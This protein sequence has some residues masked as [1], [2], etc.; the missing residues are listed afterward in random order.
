VK[1][2]IWECAYYVLKM[3]FT[4][5]HIISMLGLYEEDDEN[6]SNGSS[7][8]DDDS[9]EDL[10]FSLAWKI[11]MLVSDAILLGTDGYSLYSIFYLLHIHSRIHFVDDIVEIVREKIEKLCMVAGIAVNQF[12]LNTKIY[13]AQNV[14]VLYELCFIF[15]VPHCVDLSSYFQTVF[16]AL[17]LF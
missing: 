4:A 7:S 13:F 10:I 6:L 12:A 17:S 2:C 14:L 15:R 9:T 5:S 11:Q 3:S 16:L 8:D 1:H